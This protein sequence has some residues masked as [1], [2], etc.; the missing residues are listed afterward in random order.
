MPT[1]RKGRF[2]KSFGQ[3][4]QMWGFTLL[5]ILVVL[6][7]VGILSAIA[8]P[9]WLSFSANQSLNS[10]QSRAFSALRL[11]QSNAKRTQ[12]TWQASFRNT[13]NIA[14]YSVHKAPILESTDLAYWNN[15]PWENFDRGVRI[16]DNNEI[17]PRTTF[18]KLSSIPEPDVYRVQF[19]AK[20]N[21]NGIGELGRITFASRISD[22]RKCV[23]VSTI[24]GS[25]RFVEN[26]DC[27][28][29]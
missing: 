22:R 24:L 2:L 17:E 23:I 11:A 21:P 9:S 20:G 8:A 1:P 16:V 10:A 29:S 7:V 15:L 12:L 14:Q 13:D 18:T 25:M 5:E 28:Q 3:Y 6:M 27:N 26:L 19:D 4:R